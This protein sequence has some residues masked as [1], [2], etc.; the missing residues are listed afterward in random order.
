M[1]WYGL[2]MNSPQIT[3]KAPSAKESRVNTSKGSHLPWEEFFADHG[4]S[5]NARMR[6]LAERM[7]QCPPSFSQWAQERKLSAKDLGP[8]LSLKALDDFSRPLLKL[9][10][11][12][13]T[14]SIGKDLLDKLVDLQLLKAPLHLECQSLEAWREA[15]T[16][17]RH[18]NATA[19]DQKQTLDLP[20][21]KYAK[22]QAQRDGDR[23]VHRL[24]LKFENL[25]DGI[26][27]LESLKQTLE[28]RRD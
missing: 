4:L 16:K 12:R 3:S 2:A 25:E 23:L 17:E 7:N 8:L 21:P 27:K 13:A 26:R 28:A 18:P 5:H 11:L 6:A 22:Y 9:V 15:V 19:K 20:L 24:T 1:T 10:E 14:R